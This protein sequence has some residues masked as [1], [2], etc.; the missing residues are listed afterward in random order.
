MQASVID[1]D[2]NKYFQAM[3]IAV[4]ILAAWLMRNW[5]LPA[6]VAAFALSIPSP[7]LAAAWTATSDF[8]VISREELAAAEWARRETPPEAVFVTDGW[9]NSFTDAAGRRRLTTFAPYIANL[10]YQ[11]DERISHVTTI[12]CGGNTD[13]S[14][15]LMR[16]YGATYVVD[17]ARPSPCGAP[18]DFG[19]SP[20]FELAYGAGPR[21][22]RLA[23]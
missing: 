18:V 2:M 22:W 11:P 23:D 5:P 16:R 14:A 15:T 12:Y 21:V 19:S 4:A 10:G 20:R 7:L 9:L 8:Q 17:G 1:F 3:W 6:L 13:L